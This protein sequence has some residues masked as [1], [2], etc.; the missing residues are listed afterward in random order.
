MIIG[1]ICQT[2]KFRAGVQL[3]Y[4]PFNQRTQCRN[5]VPVSHGD[6][7]QNSLVTQGLKTGIPALPSMWFH[8]VR[9]LSD[10]IPVAGGMG[11]LWTELFQTENYAFGA[12]IRHKSNSE[13]EWLTF[14]D[15]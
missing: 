9:N 14:A 12:V 8:I 3:V 15:F 7:G 2:L 1:S 13:W 6:I 11:R 10:K 5:S 4:L